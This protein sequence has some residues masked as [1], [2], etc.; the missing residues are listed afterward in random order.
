MAVQ[1]I[2]VFARSV[3][4]KFGGGFETASDI[5]SYPCGFTGE[6][7]NLMV[8]FGFFFKLKKKNL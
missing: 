7:I 3:V 5:R 6:N 1:Q 4:R 8:D 2:S